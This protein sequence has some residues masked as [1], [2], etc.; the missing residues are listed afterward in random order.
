MFLIEIFADCKNH[1]IAE[2]GCEFRSNNK[3]RKL[4]FSPNDEIPRIQKSQSI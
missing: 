4:S 2:V 3:M 1:N